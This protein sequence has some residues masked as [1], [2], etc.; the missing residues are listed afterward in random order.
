[1]P[2]F[3]DAAKQS[4]T[5]RQSLS[6]AGCIINMFGFKFS[7][8][9]GRADFAQAGGRDAAKLDEALERVAALLQWV[10]GYAIAVRA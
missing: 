10:P 7:V 9:T 5:S 2:R 3:S 4:V 1:M 6:L 8:R